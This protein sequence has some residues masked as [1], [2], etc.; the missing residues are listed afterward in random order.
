MK[1]LIDLSVVYKQDR[2]VQDRFFFSAPFKLVSMNEEG[3]D[4]LQ[5]MLMNVSPGILDGDNYNLQVEVEKEASLQ[6]HTQAYQRLFTMTGSAQQQFLIKI[7]PNACFRIP[8][9][10]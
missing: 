2:S 10:N 8:T 7:G 5:L 1:A 9:S 4:T 3:N 6:L